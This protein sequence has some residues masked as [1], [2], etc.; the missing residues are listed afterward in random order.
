MVRIITESLGRWSNSYFGEELRDSNLTDA[1]H[2]AAT[3]FCKLQPVSA[4]RNGDCTTP[5]RTLAICQS[6]REAT[7]N[8]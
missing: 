3:P 5:S 7:H 6:T 2:G 8:L 1:S 4:D